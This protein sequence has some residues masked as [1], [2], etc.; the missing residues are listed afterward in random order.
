MAEENI[1]TT[2]EDT[3]VIQGQEN[4]KFRQGTEFS[5]EAP[6]KCFSSLVSQVQGL[7]M[8]REQ[9]HSM[10]VQSDYLAET[11]ERTQQEKRDRETQF[12]LHA[13]QLAQNTGLK[14][15]THIYCVT[16][17]WKSALSDA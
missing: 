1:S 12:T 3:K 5:E 15:K 17:R 8:L 2:S 16:W 11:K 14:R 9:L 6:Q 10:P 4:S 7:Q 13:D